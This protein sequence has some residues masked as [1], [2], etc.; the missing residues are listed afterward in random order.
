MERVA[1]EGKGVILY[2]RRDA[3]GLDLFS[4]PRADSAR[5]P[6]T[7]L[8]ASWLADFREFGIGAQILRDGGGG[9]IRWLAN[10]PLRL[11]SLPG[12]GVEIVD[13]LPLSPYD[14]RRSS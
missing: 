7:A 6:S 10:R 12:Y 1:A 14:P 11:G 4:E 9:K 3:R 5:A 2:L 8:G 13:S